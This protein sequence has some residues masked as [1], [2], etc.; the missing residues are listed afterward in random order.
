LF[1]PC[2]APGPGYSLRFITPTPFPPFGGKGVGVINR[3]YS[4][5]PY[6]ALVGEEWWHTLQWS[7]CYTFVFQILKPADK[8]K[9]PYG[10]TQSGR[11]TTPMRGGAAGK[12][13]KM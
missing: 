11:P 5:I 1:L 12:G 8:K 2:S 3:H 9:F 10:G 4:I 13:G 6:H 7:F